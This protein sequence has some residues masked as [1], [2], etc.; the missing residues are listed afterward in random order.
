MDRVNVSVIVVP[1]GNLNISSLFLNKSIKLDDQLDL[2]SSNITYTIPPQQVSPTL[3]STVNILFENTGGYVVEGIEIVDAETNNPL[4]IERAY[5]TS[6][7]ENK[8]GAI[9]DIQV[10]ANS[11]QEGVFQNSFKLNITVYTTKKQ[12]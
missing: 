9:C 7:L 3:P 2:E 10:T 1:L 6:K 5:C 8:N 12:V 11:N 4:T